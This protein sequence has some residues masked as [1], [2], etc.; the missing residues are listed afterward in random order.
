MESHVASSSMSSP[1]CPDI[2]EWVAEE[3][4]WELHKIIEEQRQMAALGL[5][6]QFRGHLNKYRDNL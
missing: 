1:S 5:P 3:K 2:V 6:L 4:E